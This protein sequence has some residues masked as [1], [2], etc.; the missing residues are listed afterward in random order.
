[1]LNSELRFKLVS[2]L[3]GALFADAGNVWLRRE[4]TGI[5]ATANNPGTP[6]RPGSGFK[7]KNALSELAV[8]AGAGLRVDASIFVVRLD[9][10]FPVRKPWLAPGDRWVFD[11]INFGNKDWRR[12][13]IIY[14]I[15]I[16]YPF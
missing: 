15:G 1:M 2:I 8:G 13:N 6:G 16:G 10:A 9:V 14:N 3:H 4:D 7:L 5:P 11:E 12:E